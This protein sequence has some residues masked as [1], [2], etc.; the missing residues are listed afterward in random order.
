MEDCKY[1]EQ[2]VDDSNSYNNTHNMCLEFY[3]QRRIDDVYVHCRK[4][5]I[6]QDMFC[7]GDCKPDD[8]YDGYPG[9]S[10]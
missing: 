5:P 2:L 4:N 9:A 7:C 1:C 3:W 6:M 10:A 8:K